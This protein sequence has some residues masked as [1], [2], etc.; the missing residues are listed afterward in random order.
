MSDLFKGESCLVIGASG[1]IGRGAVKAFLKYGAA[2]V[3]VLGRD[4]PRLEKLTNEYLGGDSRVT[5]IAA[6]VSDMD[7]ARRAAEKVKE[8]VG[9]IDHLVSSSG[10]WWDVGPLHQVEP[11]V[12]RSAMRANVDSHLYSYRYFSEMVAP[13]G[14][15]I[16]MN[17]AAADFL[18]D[19]G[20]T[21][22]CA[23]TIR[24]LC[25]VLL[26]EGAGRG[27][28]IHELLLRARVADGP[29]NPGIKSEVFGVVF[30]AIASG[31]TDYKAGTTIEVNS[32]KDVRIL[33]GLLK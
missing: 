24:G 26:Y 32:E 30:A 9:Q 15:Y 22:I 14:S 2:R 19:S 1:N 20:L 6:D 29:P 5:I 8:E 12:W 27:L 11:E 16:I 28:R 3:V 13:S 4:R 23:F 7:G 33:S 31:K 10:P 21:G 25:K 17:G 18:P